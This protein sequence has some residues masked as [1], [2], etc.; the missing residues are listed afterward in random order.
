MK[1]T[2][3][4]IKYENTLKELI[5]E[6]C[7][8]G[9][10][11]VYYDYNDKLPT[12]CIEKALDIMKEN[13]EYSFESALNEAFDSEY[14]DYETEEYNFINELKAELEN[15]ND[16]DIKDELINTED[17][18]EDLEQAGYNGIDYNL[19][20]LLKQTKFKVNIMLTTENEKNLDVTAINNSYCVPKYK[21]SGQN[22]DKNIDNGLTYLIHQQGYTTKEI[23][24]RYYNLDLI[25]EEKSSNF[26][27]SVVEELDNNPDYSMSELTALISLEGNNI[28]KFFNAYMN[29]NQNIKLDKDTMIGLFN[30]WNGSGS[31]L[32]IELEKPLIFKSSMI[33]DYQIEESGPKPYSFYTVNETY[34]LVESCWK[35]TFDI[36]DEESKLAKENL[37]D[38]IYEVEDT[39]EKEK[40]QEDEDSIL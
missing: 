9:Y 10:H 5:K 31:L 4:R 38:T 11:Q 21:F 15:I 7:K 24:D 32:E 22:V 20:E 19:K 30:K 39:L 34:G 17:F 40:E 36:T 26:L 8:N 12:G 13:K 25:K 2:R 37:S 29:D 27:D 3:N 14:F 18:Y 6:N 23:F 35:D 1:K 28:S 33:S 16:Q